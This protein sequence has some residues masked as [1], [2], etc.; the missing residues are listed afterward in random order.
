MYIKGL[1]LIY[2]SH[3]EEKFDDDYTFLSAHLIQA[4]R[5][6]GTVA[7]NAFVKENVKLHCP[8]FFSKCGTGPGWTFEEVAM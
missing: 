6:F 7:E 8:S 2:N 5:V 4:W 3:P 1:L